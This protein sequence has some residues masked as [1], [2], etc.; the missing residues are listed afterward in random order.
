M[1]ANNKVWNGDQRGI[2]VLVTSVPRWRENNRAETNPY[3]LESVR[4]PPVRQLGKAMGFRSR[5][6]NNVLNK[7]DAHATKLAVFCHLYFR[8]KYSR[9][10]SFP[11]ISGKESR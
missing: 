1:G 6:R 4:L 9:Q 5:A 11:V 7:Q 10:F 3:L 2:L 8:S